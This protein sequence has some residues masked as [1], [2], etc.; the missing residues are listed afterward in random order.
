VI[1]LVKTIKAKYKNGIIQPLEVL[2]IPDDIELT[3]TINI[4]TKKSKDNDW[5]KLRGI[6]KGT[7]ALQDHEKEHKEEIAREENP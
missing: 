2:D 1:K 7:T 4:M 3:V 6:L 5:Q